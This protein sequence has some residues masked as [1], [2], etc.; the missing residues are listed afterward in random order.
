MKFIQRLD[1]SVFFIFTIVWLMLISG[2]VNLID[3]PFNAWSGTLMGVLS[4]LF[5]I[6]SAVFFRRQV[7]LNRTHINFGMKKYR[8]EEIQRISYEQFV[9]THEGGVSADQYLVF[10]MKHR[11]KRLALNG[12]EDSVVSLLLGIRSF[13][14]TVQLCDDLQKVTCS[15]HLHLQELAK[16]AKLKAEQELEAFYNEKNKAS[17]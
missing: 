3:T 13:Y 8:W 5:S 16:I 2:I 9:R 12:L 11:Q 1:K 4:I 14:P 15:N 17:Q 7:I 6:G 10:E